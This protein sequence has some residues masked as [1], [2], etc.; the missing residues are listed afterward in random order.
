MVLRLGEVCRFVYACRISRPWSFEGEGMIECIWLNN[1]IG[2]KWQSTTN[3]PI[4]TGCNKS[5]EVVNY[6]DH[7][8]FLENKITSQ[9]CF[10]MTTHGR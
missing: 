10:Y 9:S 3:C 6:K 7:Q 1:H 5:L 2:A 8:Y 4:N